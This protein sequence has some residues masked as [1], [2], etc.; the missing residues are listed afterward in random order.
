MNDSTKHH[1]TKHHSPKH[2]DERSVIDD[3]ILYPGDQ[4]VRRILVVEDEPDIRMATMVRLRS[5]GY[6]VDVASNGKECLEKLL[7]NDYNVVSMDIRMPVMDGLTA[8]AAMRRDPNTKRIPVI[9]ISASPGDQGHA[10]D[11]GASYFIR[12]PF[13]FSVLAKAIESTLRRQNG[14]IDEN[15]LQP[16]H[17]PHANRIS[18]P[19]EH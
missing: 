5:L 3:E 10:L 7:F 17:P 15:I 19:I 14:Q 6:E 9:V 2:H 18:H 4:Q 12:K 1:S 16:M 8:M 13:Q 11:G